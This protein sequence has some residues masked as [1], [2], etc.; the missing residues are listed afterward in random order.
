MGNEHKGLT[1]SEARAYYD[2]FGKMVLIARLIVAAD[3][4]QFYTAKDAQTAFF[5]PILPLWT[6]YSLPSF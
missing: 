6:S 2:R 4:P 5:Y 1:A 3:M